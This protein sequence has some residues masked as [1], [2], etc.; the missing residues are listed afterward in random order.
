M[1]KHIL[2]S[3]VN[4]VVFMVVMAG[5]MLAGTTGVSAE[6]IRNAEDAWLGQGSGTADDPYPKLYRVP[7]HNR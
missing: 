3:F 4:I 1:K 2:R 7:L 5:A 6:L